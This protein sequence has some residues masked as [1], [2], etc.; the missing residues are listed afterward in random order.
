MTTKNKLLKPD[1]EVK[2]RKTTYACGC[3]FSE[4]EDFVTDKGE[5]PGKLSLTLCGEHKGVLGSSAVEQLIQAA[6]EA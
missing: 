1:S 3:S 6:L 4:T 5:K 2:V